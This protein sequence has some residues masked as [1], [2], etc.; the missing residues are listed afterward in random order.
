MKL[1][2][3]LASFVVTILGIIYN[4]LIPEATDGLIVLLMCLILASLFRIEGNH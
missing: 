2:L 4:V 1:L 3:A